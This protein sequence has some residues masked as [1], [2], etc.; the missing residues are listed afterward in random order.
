[1]EDKINNSSESKKLDKDYVVNHLVSC[2][3]NANK[4]MSDALNEKVPDD[5]LNAR[6]KIYLGDVFRKCNV[7]FKNP[8]KGGIKKAMEE[9]KSNIINT[10]GEERGT[11]LVNKYY[12]E[13]D[14]VVERMKDN[15]SD[16]EEKE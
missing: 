14:S 8:T 1:M 4:E 12:P 3:T 15:D 7:D 10:L 5:E 6:V 2:F 16:P 13:M 11:E 9:C